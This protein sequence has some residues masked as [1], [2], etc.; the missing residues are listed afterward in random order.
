MPSAGFKPAI[1]AS[2][3]PQ[4]HALEQLQLQTQ[5]AVP[6]LTVGKRRDVSV[7][8]VYVYVRYRVLHCTDSSVC[9]NWC[10]VWWHFGIY[11]YIYT[12]TY[13]YILPD[14]CI[15]RRFR[16]CANATEY[17]HKPRQYSIAYCKTVQHVT[18]LNTVG[19]CNKMVRIIIL[20]YNIMGPPSYEYMWSVVDR[21]AFR[22]R[23]HVI[24][25]LDSYNMYVCMSVCTY[26]C[27]YIYM[28]ICVYIYVCMFVRSM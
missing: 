12:H 23:T 7:C 26:V 2:K 4:T 8:T 16:R 13:R 5:Y 20:Y 14:K 24:C 19:N 11:I 6:I 28:F 21:N 15:L 17:L 22:R 10:C 1:R 25:I 9:C 3:W 27:M 18:V